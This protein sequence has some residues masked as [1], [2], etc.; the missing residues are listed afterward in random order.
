MDGR[1]E[2]GLPLV[3]VTGASA[4][5]GAATARRLGAD[6]WHVVLVARR[7][8]RLRDVA[9]PRAGRWLRRTGRR[10]GR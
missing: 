1:E 6:G 10:R 2:S 4:G 3:V 8:E 7:E 9:A 5:I